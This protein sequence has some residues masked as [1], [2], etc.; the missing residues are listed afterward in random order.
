MYIPQYNHHY[1][2]RFTVYLLI[3]QIAQEQGEK[4]RHLGHLKKG[5][6]SWSSGGLIKLEINYCHPNL[7]CLL[8]NDSI[9]EARV[10]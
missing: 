5:F 10:V 9:Y 6:T 7:S 1:V 8:S 3:L 4:E 2:F